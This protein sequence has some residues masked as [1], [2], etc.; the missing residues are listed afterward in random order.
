[1]SVYAPASVQ[2][3]K[4]ALLKWW[5]NEAPKARVEIGKRFNVSALTEPVT[6]LLIATT[7]EAFRAGWRAAERHHHNLGRQTSLLGDEDE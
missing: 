6:R 1:M 7:G 3:L 5:E 2:D 4:D